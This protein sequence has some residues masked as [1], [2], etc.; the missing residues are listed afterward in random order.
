VYAL[1]RGQFCHQPPHAWGLETGQLSR[2]RL[3]LWRE[4][5]VVSP[6]GGLG[7]GTVLVPTTAAIPAHA[8][9][10]RA[11]PGG[12]SER[13]APL[14]DAGERR[15]A[16]LL[17]A[18]CRFDSRRPHIP[19]A[20]LSSLLHLFRPLTGCA[21]TLTTLSDISVA[22]PGAHCPGRLLVCPPPGQQLAHVERPDEQGNEGRRER[23]SRIAGGLAANAAS[24]PSPAQLG[25]RATHA[26]RIDNSEL[27]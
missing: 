22:G 12:Y 11:W 1:P 5:S 2:H 3:R 21:F 27:V 20:T 4:L 23:G 15:G 17:T 7:A 10:H 24:A 18:D 6:A 9:D 26:T 16:H 14:T 13:E 25:P 19:R 8:H